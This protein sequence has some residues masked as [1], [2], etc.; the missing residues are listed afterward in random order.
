MQLAHP[1][2]EMSTICEQQLNWLV[3]YHLF[4]KAKYVCQSESHFFSGIPST[5]FLQAFHTIC[6]Q[7]QSV[8]LVCNLVIL[9]YFCFCTLV[10]CQLFSIP[11]ALVPQLMNMVSHQLPVHLI[12][13][14]I[15]FKMWP[16]TPS[17]PIAFYVSI[18]SSTLNII[19][20]LTSGS[21]IPAV[22]IVL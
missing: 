22:W 20:L 12:V 14:Y 4:T 1:S 13:V 3:M 10:C 5:V 2:L 16:D 11:L 6:R 17:G 19:S 7:C 8:T 9:L 15:P 18:S 21:C